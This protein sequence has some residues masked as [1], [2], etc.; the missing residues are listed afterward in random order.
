MESRER[1]QDFASLERWYCGA[2][3][4]YMHSEPKEVAEIVSRVSSIFNS[5]N[6]V[7]QYT[8]FGGYLMERV[9]VS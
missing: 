1:S 5:R 7:I 9:R 6:T 8:D 3:C 2:S 4:H